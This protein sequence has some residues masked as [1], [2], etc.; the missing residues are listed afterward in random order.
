MFTL[1]NGYLKSDQCRRL[2]AVIWIGF[3]CVRARVSVCACMRS[4]SVCVQVRKKRG[5]EREREIQNRMKRS[6]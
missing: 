6:L 4:S 3:Q 1:I 2:I 5:V